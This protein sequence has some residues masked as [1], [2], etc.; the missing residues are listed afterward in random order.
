MGPH[1]VGKS[2]L[3]VSF[4]HEQEP[5]FVEVCHALSREVVVAEKIA[6]VGVALKG[7]FKQLCIQ[8]IC[9]DR[10]SEFT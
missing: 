5:A 2:E 1:E 9:I 8:R 10:E 7:R 3:G 6:A 4:S